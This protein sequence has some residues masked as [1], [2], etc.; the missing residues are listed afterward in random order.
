[1]PVG[2]LAQQGLHTAPQTRI[3]GGR[4]VH[5]PPPPPHQPAK[6]RGRTR[7]R[8]T[9]AEQGSGAT[10]AP[11]PPPHQP[12]RQ[13]RC[14]GVVSCGHRLSIPAARLCVRGRK[15]LPATIAWSCAWSPHELEQLSR[16]RSAGPAKSR[17]TPPRKVDTPGRPRAAPPTPLNASETAGPSGDR[18]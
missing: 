12:N 16:M 10:V 5:P 2:H 13:R 3:L 9:P 14:E 18:I 6:P 11:P 1:V 17:I 8:R 15:Q 7:A 4:M